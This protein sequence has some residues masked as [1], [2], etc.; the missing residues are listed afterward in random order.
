M[1]IALLSAVQAN[2]RDTCGTFGMGPLEQ[3][4]RTNSKLKRGTFDMSLR[5]SGYI[6]A[7]YVATIP[8]LSFAQIRSDPAKD[9]PLCI[10]KQKDATAAL[11]I[12]DF[13]SLESISRQL[14]INCKLFYDGSFERTGRELLVSSL[15]KLGRISEARIAISECLK[16]HYRSL[17]CRWELATIY[18]SSGN[19]QA[20]L[21]VKEQIMILST[22]LIEEN[23][24]K[25][26]SINNKKIINQSDSLSVA[27]LD[28]EH[29]KI[30][31]INEIEC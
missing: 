7:F 19:K 18:R 5:V 13:V 8:H 28:A 6:V 4:Q 20:C 23:A 3:C 25:L 31:A 1:R 27:R 21:K 2:Q 11:N 15:R 9:I 10:E 24:D 22:S 17:D 12:K 26:E 30:Q 16:F 14:I 29:S